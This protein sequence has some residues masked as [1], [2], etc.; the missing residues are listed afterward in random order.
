MIM[1]QKLY[2][3]KLSDADMTNIYILYIR[4]ILEQSCQV[5][6]FSITQEERNDLERVQKTACKII[7]SERYSDYTSALEAL[8]LE[9]LNQRRYTLS[10]KFAKK[11]L[12]YEQTKY[13]FPLNNTEVA[14]MR[15]KQ[16]YQV[17]FAKTSRLLK[18]SIPQLQR[19]LNDDVNANKK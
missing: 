9:T 16:K 13:M 8:N 15:Q 3:F 5:W 14:D 7:L 12:K 10:L 4:S 2:P 6:H 18:S 19:A 1:L 17:K 11:C